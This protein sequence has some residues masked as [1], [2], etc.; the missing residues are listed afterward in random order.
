MTRVEEVRLQVAIRE[1]V[2]A[3]EVEVAGGAAR[4]RNEVVREGEG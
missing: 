3:R 2:T 1:A 4:S